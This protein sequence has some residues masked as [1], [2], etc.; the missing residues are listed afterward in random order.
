[1]PFVITISRFTFILND[2]GS[3]R[4]SVDLQ[5]D[6]IEPKAGN[7]THRRLPRDSFRIVRG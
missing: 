6:V 4:G 5:G 7:E 1:M 3:I 2:L